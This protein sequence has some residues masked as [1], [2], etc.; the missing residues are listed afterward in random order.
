MLVSSIGYFNKKS[1]NEFFNV[2]NKTQVKIDNSKFGQMCDV[3]ISE[4]SDNKNSLTS[5]CVQNDTDSTEKLQKQSLN[6][7]A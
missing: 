4:L 6:M 3:Q 2:N 1:F 7:I 5:G